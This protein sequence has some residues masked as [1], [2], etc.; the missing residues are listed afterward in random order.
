[1]KLQ[2]SVLCPRISLCIVQFRQ[3][4]AH[5]SLDA[6]FEQRWNISWREFHQ[7]IRNN[8]NLIMNYTNRKKNISINYYYRNMCIIIY[9]LNFYSYKL[10]KK[11]FI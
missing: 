4:T 2:C 1:M 3:V 7:T 11:L 8:I 5:E 6:R 10:N 9:Y